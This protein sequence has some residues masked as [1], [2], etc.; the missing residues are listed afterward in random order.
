MTEKIKQ[1]TPEQEAL[2][3]V[4]HQHWYA[5]G[6][7]TEPADRPTAEESISWIYGKIGQKRPHF[8]WCESPMQACI[9]IHLLHQGVAD[10]FA[11]A[12]E[13]A[14]TAHEVRA[15][16]PK[17]RWSF[18][19]PP[20]SPPGKPITEQC[21]KPLADKIQ[22]HQPGEP[23]TFR[24]RSLQKALLLILHD[25][26][27]NTSQP[28]VWSPAGEREL[29]DQIKRVFEK[30]AQTS[31]EDIKASIQTSVRESFWGQHEVFWI[32]Y[33]RYCESVLGIQYDSESTEILAHHERI[34]RSAMWWWPYEGYC[35]VC[36]RP[37]SVNM[38]NGRLHNE[39][40]GAILFRDGW[41][42]YAIDGVH[43]PSWLIDEPERLT[44]ELIEAMQNIEVRRIMIDRYGRDRYLMD[45]GAQEI[46]RDDWG[47]LYR[48]EQD[49]DEPLVM[50]KVVNATPEADGTFRD[51]FVRV[52]PE[53]RPLLGQGR[54]GEPQEM[55]ARNA[56]ASTFRKRG[57]EYHPEHET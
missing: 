23:Q 11:Q 14:R 40:G 38:R 44:V 13:A 8:I 49:G 47:I 55:T 51:Y 57:K 52:H 2:L 21:W 30:C 36:D 26:F 42:V 28:L 6:T 19:V 3:P 50:V 4:Y 54:L 45:S 43:V 56:V 39:T 12:F 16:M 22:D 29:Y 1:L 34:A 37:A 35:I 15:S 5:I 24:E 7:C 25:V 41:G 10:Q 32:A 9:T 27:S 53:L 18:R 17:Q 48:K 46:H 20:F 31:K 33:Y